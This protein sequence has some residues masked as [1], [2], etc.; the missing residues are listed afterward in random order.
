LTK[1]LVTAVDAISQQLNEIDNHGD[2]SK[3]RQQLNGIAKH[4]GRSKTE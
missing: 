1:T 3:I 2:G 4:G